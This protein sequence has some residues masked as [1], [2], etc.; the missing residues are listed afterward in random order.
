MRVGAISS[1]RPF[2]SVAAPRGP[3][4]LDLLALWHRRATSRAM[5][6]ELPPDRL[7]DI[8]MTPMNAAIEAARPFWKG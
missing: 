7:R 1:P 6:R 3:G 5:L 4:L 2:A 8:G